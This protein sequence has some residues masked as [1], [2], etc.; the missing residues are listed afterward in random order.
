MED[1]SIA[2]ATSPILSNASASSSAPEIHA[3]TQFSLASSVVTSP[4]LDSALLQSASPRDNASFEVPANPLLSPDADPGILEALTE[5]LRSKDRIYV[6]KLG[7]L[8]EGLINERRAR[9]D[10][11]PTTSYQRMLVHRCSA[12]YRL[13]PESDSASKA[14]FV[15]YR[16]ESRI[17]VRRVSELV[18]VEENAQPAFKIMR[19]TVQDR[20]RSRYNSQPGSVAGEDADLSDV[21]QSETSSVGGRSNATG[22]SK[23]HLTI[24]EREAAYKEARSRIFMGFEEKEAEKEKDS[25]ANSSTHSLVSGS[26]S[27]S[28]GRSSAGDADDSASSAATESEWSGP[29]TREKRD[30]W[31]AGSTTSSSRST[32]LSDTSYTKNGSGSSRNSRA[33]SPSF[34]YPT[35]YDP[36]NAASSSYDPAY[37][38]QGPPHGYIQYYYPY[39]PPANMAAQPPYMAPYPYYPYGYASPP[40]QPSPHHSDPTS[41]AATDTGY[42]QGQPPPLPQIAGYPNTYMWPQPH[43]GHQ[44]PHMPPPQQGTHPVPPTPIQQPSSQGQAGQVPYGYAQGPYAY[45]VPYYPP[46]QFPQGQPMQPPP[47]PPHTQP[48]GHQYPSEMMYPVENPALSFSNGVHAVDSNGNSR[49]SSRNSNH[50]GANGG[51]RRGGPPRPRQ[52]W[53]YGPGASGV[54][55]QYGAQGSEQV[56]PRLTTRRTSGTSSGSGSAGNRTPGDEASSTTSSSTTSSSSR[57]TFT[58]TSSKHP[59]PARPDWAVG[60]KA[61]TGLHPPRSHDHSNPHSRNMSPARIGGQAL[62]SNHHPHGQSQQQPSPTD[63]PPL[64]SGPSPEK[65]PPPPAVPSAWA[66]THSNRSIMSPG[67]QTSVNTSAAGSALVHYPNNGADGQGAPMGTEEN[68]ERP[69]PKGTAELFNPKGT[70]VGRKSVGGRPNMGPVVDK[71]NNRSGIEGENLRFNLDAMQAIPALAEKMGGISMGEPSSCLG[72]GV[73]GGPAATAPPTNGAGGVESSVNSS[74]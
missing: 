23:R 26:G 49:T 54:G 52:A 60:L 21:E 47:T 17:P 7:E 48:P 33:T 51:P 29:A 36:S 37:G 53:S 1:P 50:M 18:P 6:L 19:R 73:D 14:I 55:F 72:V 16:S 71:E 65:R 22:T 30:G 45:Q 35:L 20:A 28:G 46:T 40:H 41:P 61:H 69:P 59:L 56:G 39:G 67:P 2:T 5:A 12:Y 66:N 3:T 44:P 43:A 25:S 34:T 70:A 68:F 9:I 62:L 58:S 13:T 32:R 24:E 64:S 42:L 63:F 38:A 10:V 15:H 4:S 8:M 57:R 31:R 27:T 11:T 74:S